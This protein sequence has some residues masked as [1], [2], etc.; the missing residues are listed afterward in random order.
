MSKLVS[1]DSTRHTRGAATGIPRRPRSDG[2]A[3]RRAILRASLRILRDQGL[4]TLTHRAV[5]AEAGV[6]LA[7]TSYH[8]SSKENLIAAALDLAAVETTETLELAAAELRTA[9][10]TLTPEGVADR[11]CD[12][13]MSRLGDE[14]LAVLSVVELSLAAARRPEL[15]P[16]VADWNARYR[17]IVVDLLSRCGLPDPPAAATIVVGTLEGLVFLQLAES[18]RDFEHAVLRPSMRTLLRSLSR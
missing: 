2:A 18:D 11:L 3:T 17:A 13:E 5:S 12:L 1:H 10:E 4:A 7:L 14:H 9:P 6:S 8:F 15:Q 16:A